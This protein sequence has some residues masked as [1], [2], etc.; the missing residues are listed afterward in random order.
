MAG[1]EILIDVKGVAKHFGEGETR[2]DALRDVDLQV[3]AG[4]VIALLGPSGSGKTTLLNVIGCILTPS[5]GR[6]TLDGET[7]FDGQWLRRDLRRLRLD[8]IGFIFQTHN[9]LP[10]LTAEEN[11]AVVLDLAGWPVEKGRTRAGDLL[12]YLEV[13]HRAAAK[14][15]LL[16]G[17][18]AQ[19]VAI[20]RALANR[21]RIILA[22]EPTAALDSKRAGLV[23]DLL[24][25][26]AVEQEA[27]IVTVTH[28]EKIFDRFDRLIH[29]RDGRLAD[30]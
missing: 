9:L 13:D 17:G 6:V 27:C 23:M 5:A 22:D 28:D 16:S 29:L 25:K 15:A 11:V 19:R 20:A 21:P 24:R 4:E 10:F 12:G 3:R 26:L 1:G 14:P 2:V 7:V 8:K 18:E 30:A